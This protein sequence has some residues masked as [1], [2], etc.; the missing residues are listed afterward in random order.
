M[1]TDFD[2]I[3]SIIDLDPFIGG[4]LHFFHDTLFY[5]YEPVRKKHA[6]TRES[7]DAKMLNLVLSS[8][9]FLCLG[10]FCIDSINQSITDRRVEIMSSEI[11]FMHKILVMGNHD[12]A[13]IDLYKKYNWEVISF[14]VN[15][16]DNTEDINS[17]PYL[18]FET[19][20]IK[21]LCTHY[22]AVLLSKDWRPI[23]RDFSS[24]LYNKYKELGAD[25]NLHGHTHSIHMEGDCFKNLSFDGDESFLFRRLSCVTNGV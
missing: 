5:T 7:F 10:D 23:Y 9:P 24:I 17:P 2:K 14:G 22:P 1:H 21:V 25:I 3:K 6:T 18:F 4:D 15:L 11:K 13:P 19:K 16:V 12:K 8:N 20:G